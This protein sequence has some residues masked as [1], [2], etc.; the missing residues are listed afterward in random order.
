LRI[1]HAWYHYHNFFSTMVVVSR[2]TGG[3]EMKFLLPHASMGIML[4]NIFIEVACTIHTTEQV[5]ELM[6]IV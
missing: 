3:L 6:S 4:T 1:K 5:I 2:C